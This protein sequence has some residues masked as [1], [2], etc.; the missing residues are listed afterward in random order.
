MTVRWWICVYRGLGFAARHYYKIKGNFVRFQSSQPS[1]VI[2]S[3]WQARPRSDGLLW[4]GV[5]WSQLLLLKSGGISCKSCLLCVIS[6]KLTPWG[7]NLFL[8]MECSACFR[9]YSYMLCDISPLS[10]GST[11][12]PLFI[13]FMLLPFL[14]IYLYFF[15]ESSLA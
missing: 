9:L 12:K 5:S 6:L 15:P 2:L 11:Y 10:A 14:P 13:C 8:A 4:C 7:L 1:F 3:C